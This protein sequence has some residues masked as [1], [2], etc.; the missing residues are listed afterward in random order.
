MLAIVLS[1]LTVTAGVSALAFERAVRRRRVVARRLGLL[2][3][4]AEFAGRGGRWALI[5]TWLSEAFEPRKIWRGMARTARRSLSVTL[6]MGSLALTLGIGYGWWLMDRS[7]TTWGVVGG[8]S[9]ALLGWY[10]LG[11]YL[12]GRIQRRKEAIAWSVPALLD[13]IVC[14]VEVGVGFESALGS[15]VREKGK[16]DRT[17]KNEL[18]RYLQETRLGHTRQEALVALA[19][20]CDVP[21]LHRM[22]GAVLASRDDAAALRAQLRECALALQGEWLKKKRERA[23]R[24]ITLMLG[25]IVTCF[26]PLMAIALGAR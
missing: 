10:L 4:D 25:I 6:L 2:E 20:R 13:R 15:V 22:V 8:G 11:G 5:A 1:I 7:G 23:K 12:E 17:L 26:G 21:E 16:G 3:D 18:F 19:Q 14:L 24:A 9:L